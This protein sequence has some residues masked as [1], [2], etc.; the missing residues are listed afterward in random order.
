MSVCAFALVGYAIE[1]RAPLQG[2]VNFAVTN[3]VGALLLLFGIALVYGR[4]G[5]LNLA[6]IGQT[7]QG[8][9]SD[10]LL[11]VAFAL[12]LVGFLV[13]AGAVPFHFWLSDAYAV[14]PIPVCVVL[15]GVM[16]DLGLH[17]LARIYWP[18]FS[19]VLSAHAGSLRAVLVG[20]GVL[21]AL[22]GGTMAFFQRDLKRLIAFVTIGH[23]GIFLAGIG[24][25][26]ARALAGTTLY[27][28]ADGFVKGGLFLA[29]G[30]LLR[31]AGDGDEL[32]LRG[33]GGL[34]PVAG[35]A[36]LLGALGLA[37]LPPFGTFPGSALIIQSARD[38]GYGWLPPLLAAAAVLTAGTVMRAGARIFL[39]LGDEDDPSLSH[40]PPAAAAEPE[41]V[42]R[43]VS[44]PL[45]FGPALGLIAVGLGLAF[46]PG[47][48]GQATQWAQRFE[49]RPAH[50]AEVLRGAK[51]TRAPVP[52][53][54]PGA[55][56]YVYGGISTVGAIGFAAFGLYRRRLPG[57]VRRVPGRMVAVPAVRLKELHSGVVGDYVAWLTFGAA[58]LGGLLA[59]TVR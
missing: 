29:V 8:K 51:P 37:G 25:L 44:P 48:A 43:R 35:I 58:A 49:D 47:L 10:G 14:A 59:L 56:P 13:K 54:R 40:E 23:V 24:L 38:V 34:A 52:A 26:T 21:T 45:L 41:E 18:A 17:G 11:V 6:Q 9:R 5:A 15:S 16:S 1:H 28:L 57:L 4:T 7:L 20:A 42:P 22:V 19:A 39:G 30:V 2:A 33:R 50:S 53:F 32:R 3:T 55:A 36:F 46:M 27:V 12:L 31:Q